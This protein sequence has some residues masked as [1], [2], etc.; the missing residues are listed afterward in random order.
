M[1]VLVPATIA[2][3]LFVQ[4]M[5]YK[6]SVEAMSQTIE[7]TTTALADEIL[8]E[9]TL[10]EIAQYITEQEIPS[11]EL[12]A[13]L[14]SYDINIEEQ[15]TLSKYMT[16]A[17]REYYATLYP[18]LYATAP[19]DFIMETNTVY[20]TFDD[21]P[22]DVT[23]NV[24][25]IL[26][27]HEVKATFFVT[28][29]SSENSAAI[30]RKIVEDG[31]TL[32]VHTYTHD[33]DV[34]YDSVETFLEDF[35]AI[36]NFIYE[37]TGVQADIFRFAGGSI[38][39]HNQ[40]IYRQI[41][42]EMTRRGFVYYDWN[43]SAEDADADATWT[44]I[45]NSVTDGLEGKDRAIVLLHD[46]AWS[47]TTVLTLDDIILHVKEKGYDLKPLTNEVKPIVFGFVE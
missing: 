46:A 34:I 22:S 8:H 26:K 23:L 14:K 1:M 38:N 18:E 19:D 5:Q 39:G 44:S 17:Q 30:L 43:V 32:A 25:S 35:N 4:N 7:E 37:S 36:Y 3:V 6:K 41:I 9:P 40:D 20:L 28:K 31:H 42:A 16:V 2:I 27:K 45:Y 47:Y 21:G 12:L 29:G 15:L 13:A 10:D 11:D 24:L 33:Y